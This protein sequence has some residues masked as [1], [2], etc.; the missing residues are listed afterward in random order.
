MELRELTELVDIPSVRVTGYR[1]ARNRIEL[2]VELKNESAVCP[3]C[4]VRST[5]K[6]SE[7]MIPIRD[8][9]C[10]GRKVY[11]LLPQRRFKCNHCGKPFTEQLSFVNCEAGFTK[12]Y[13]QYVYV[14]CKG[15]SFL[16]VGK[17]E[18]ISETA[19]AKI[20]ES[21][22]APRTQEGAMPKAIRTRRRGKPRSGES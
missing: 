17:Q 11:L 21:Y 1:K 10:S 19:I 18:G 16:V 22:A 9:P 5:R 2:V 6:H 15:P 4:G 8:L 12:R 14:Q 3:Q 20:C 7:K 13:E